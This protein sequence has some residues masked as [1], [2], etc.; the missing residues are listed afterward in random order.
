MASK[1]CFSRRRFLKRIALAGAAAVGAPYVVPARVLGRDGQV[2][3]SE[4]I[5]LGAIGLGFAWQSGMAFDGVRLLAVC[6]VQRSR[7]SSAKSQVDKHY[8]NRDCQ[9]CGD[10]R[11]V[12]GRDDI[13]AVY[14]ATPDHWHAPITIAAARA[15]KHIYC[16][17]PLTHTVAEGRA[18]VEA[19]NRY[20]V[21][22]QHGTQHRSEW[23][24]GAAATLVQGGHL[25]R[26]HT[27]R[28]GMPSGQRC[29]IQPTQPVPD[30]F[31]Y[32]MWLGPAPWAPFT[33]KRCFGIHSWYF[34]SDYCVGYIAGW[35]VHHLDS[36]QHGHGA[37]DVGPKWVRAKAI[38][39]TEG[40]YNTPIHYRVDFEYADGVTM[41]CIDTANY[42]SRPSGIP[43]AKVREIHGD[44][45]GRHRFGVLFEG[46]EGSAFVW[47][48]GRLETKPESLRSVVDRNMPAT[49]KDYGTPGH[50]GNWFDCI[51]SGR[52]TNAPVEVGHRS[53]TLCN[54]GTISMSLGRDLQWDPGAER[55]DDDD[56]ANR[57]L[58]Y[59][60][61][62]PWGL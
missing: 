37:D 58:S 22:F 56:E 51:R 17:K 19:V 7:L 11:E 38:F 39:P 36:G 61:R 40:L 23:A 28:L 26:L 24:F 35:G 20:G 10:F 27:I 57:M 16:Q 54:I 34:I 53:T 13:D 32:D 48:E 18:V 14:I 15:G 60:M 1:Q 12:I 31:D 4:T 45:A 25:G 49:A 43:A 46:T 9:A 59:P 47:R 6:D 44:A 30:G 50:F 29:P 42:W 55:F 41:T 3:P 5:T 21:V 8:R 62:E 52:R 2:P 33:S